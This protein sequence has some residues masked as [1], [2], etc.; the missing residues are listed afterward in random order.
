[1]RSPNKVDDRTVSGITVRFEYWNRRR[2]VLVTP[3][4]DDVARADCYS[5]LRVWTVIGSWAVR[6]VTAN[7]GWTVNGSS[8][9]EVL[10]EE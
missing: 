3:D 8:P 10:D 2:D 7:H 6:F 1:M 9:L 4:E 5:V